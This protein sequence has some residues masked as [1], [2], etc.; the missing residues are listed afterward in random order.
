[1]KKKIKLKDIT[2][3]EYDAFCLHCR[4]IYNQCENCPLKSVVCSSE[5]YLCW[6]YHKELYSDH[7]LNK[8][9]NIDKLLYFNET[10]KEY[11]HNLLKPFKGKI[12]YITKRMFI[13]IKKE[14]LTI[15]IKDEDGGHSIILPPFDMGTMYVKLDTNKVYSK[16][17]LE[18]LLEEL[19]L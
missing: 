9:I 8:V 6:F 2:L 16:K 7:F 11:L 3:K 4:D 18:S 15:C 13:D 1:M 17:L 5:A 10:E 14:Y 12:S 19:E